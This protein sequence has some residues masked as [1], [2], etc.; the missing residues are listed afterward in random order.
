MNQ[1]SPEARKRMAAIMRQKFARVCT[2][3]ELV[4]NITDDELIA[5]AERH[6]AETEAKVRARTMSN[7][8]ATALFTKR[9]ER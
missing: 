1:L 5:Q 3:A 7:A 8:V 9:T 6:H 4:A 2:N